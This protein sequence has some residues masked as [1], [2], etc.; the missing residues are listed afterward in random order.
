[1]RSWWRGKAGGL[2]AFAVIAGLVG[3]GLGWVTLA[4]LRLE[5]EQIEARLEAE[6][7][8]KTRLALWRLDTRVFTDLAQ[9]ANRPYQH[10]RLASLSL[11]TA[12]QRSPAALDVLELV[13]TAGGEAPSW[14]QRHFLVARQADWKSIANLQDAVARDL[15][16]AKNPSGPPLPTSEQ[17]PL[18]ADLAR[19]ETLLQVLSSAGHPGS[20]PAGSAGEVR[21][22]ASGP[23]DANT[24]FPNNNDLINFPAQQ[25][26]ALPMTDRDTQARYNRAQVERGGQAAYANAARP[27]ANPPKS[28]E[29]DQVLTIFGPLVPLWVSSGA[30]HRLALTRLVQVWQKRPYHV[31]QVTLLDWPELRRILREEVHDLLPGVQLQ[32][33]PKGPSPN[34]QR[35]MTAL[36]V[37][38]DSGL[39]EL[40]APEA[41]WSPLRIGLSLAWTAALMGLSAV[42]LGGWSLLNLSERR[43]RF[44]SA[45][46]HELRTPLTT[47]RLYLD[48]LA[49][50][51]IHDE[52]RKT[53]Y[54]Q[55]LNMEAD[56]LNRLVGNVL[57]FSRLENQRPRLEKAAIAV[58]GLLAQVQTTWQCRCR[59][60][61][62]ELVIDNAAGATV[63]LVTDIHLV[64]QILGNLIDNACKYSRGALDRRIWV[65]ARSGPRGRLLLEVEDRGLGVPAREQRSI[66]RPFRRGRGDHA[67]V[68][69]VGLGLALAQ[70]WARLLGGKLTLLRSPQQGGAC[71]RLELP[72]TA[73]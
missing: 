8:N 51:L 54:I 28:A 2:L 17:E 29:S 35:A 9:E 30:E 47:L 32:A 10:Y 64:D 61:E 33:I 13:P 50:G 72:C 1:V 68:G 7:S 26:Q 53:E 20:P 73:P 55:T 62:K 40:P 70:R 3:G 6:R 21:S 25:P 31:A 71:F 38:L 22:V 27:T 12:D 45:V 11:P 4:A 16:L 34:P 69:G 56:R 23:P 41:R 48:M 43:I 18:V 36:P 52:Q 67:T 49:T 19:D 37:E 44:V 5:Q 39:G 63:Q 42:G 58:G 60:A 57:D 66:F 46:T 24:N 59:N 65:R 15:G 14:M